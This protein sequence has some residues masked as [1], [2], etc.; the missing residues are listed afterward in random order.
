[1]WPNPLQYYLV[2]DIEM[3]NGVDGDEDASK[4]DKPSH[5]F[6]TKRMA[7]ALHRI[8]KGLQMLADEDPDIE[9]SARLQKTV[10]ED[11]TCNQEIYK[12]KKHAAEQPNICTF[13]Q[14]L[15]TMV[16]ISG[17]PF[18]STPRN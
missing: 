10:M 7:T 5:K 1:M 17:E 4:E 16:I 9:R 12:E 3:E 11:L 18:P 2:P 8:Q 13:F 14:P 6:T 15:A